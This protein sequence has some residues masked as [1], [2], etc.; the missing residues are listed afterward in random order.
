MEGVSVLRSN[1]GLRSPSLPDPLLVSALGL[2]K[3]GAVA[4][5]S[6]RE[7]A[8]AG[9][10]KRAAWAAGAAPLWHGDGDEV[11]AAAEPSGEAGAAGR[12]RA[13]LPRRRSAHQQHCSSAVCLYS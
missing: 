7:A 3:D 4:V 10:K 13:A 8:L 2:S 11:R 12:G 6:G 9:R 1:L 5:A